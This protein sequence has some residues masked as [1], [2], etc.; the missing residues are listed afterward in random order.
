[1]KGEELDKE[2]RKVMANT[3]FLPYLN[4]WNPFKNPVWFDMNSPITYTEVKKAIDN[5]TLLSIPLP[6]SSPATLPVFP[7]EIHIR[8][9]AYLVVNLDPTP[10]DIDVGVLDLGCVV[11][12]I[13]TDGNHR[14]AAAFYREDDSIQ[15]YLQGDINL[16]T[17]LFN[18]DLSDPRYR[19]P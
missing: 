19:E 2:I 5:N 3:I 12:W 13:I 7:R 8:R 10:I 4:Q 6:L 9:V 14:L 17:E 1:M 18:L 11:E 15:A 16:F